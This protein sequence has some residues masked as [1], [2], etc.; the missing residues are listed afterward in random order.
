MCAKFDH[1]SFSR[2][3]HHW[4]RPFQGRF[5]IRGLA[6]STI[7]LSIKFEVFISTHY[8]DMKGDKKYQKWGDLG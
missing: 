3:R 1:Y 6:L 7:N 2:S 4:P 5:A 8:E